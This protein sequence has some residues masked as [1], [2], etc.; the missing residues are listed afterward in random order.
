MH[1]CNSFPKEQIQHFLSS[2]GDYWKHRIQ[3][4]LCDGGE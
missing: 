4:Q 3:T 1:I 2:G